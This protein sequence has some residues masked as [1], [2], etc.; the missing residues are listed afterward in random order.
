M[1]PWVQ[2]CRDTDPTYPTDK[3]VACHNSRC[4]LARVLRELVGRYTIGLV[5]HAS[6]LACLAPGGL[7]PLAGGAGAHIPG[8]LGKVRNEEPDGN[9]LMK[10]DSREAT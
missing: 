6:E 8:K 4:T 5:G 10:F 1:S 2:R 3:T 9:V 7:Q